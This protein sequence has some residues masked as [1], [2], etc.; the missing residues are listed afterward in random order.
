MYLI[1]GYVQMCATSFKIARNL[2]MITITVYFVALLLIA[3][4][5][6]ILLK[7]VANQ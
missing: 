6:N 3:K 4:Y 7:T 5:I 1:H 2:C